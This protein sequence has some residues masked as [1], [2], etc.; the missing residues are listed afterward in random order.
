MYILNR[1][2]GRW[3]TDEVGLHLAGGVFRE[4]LAGAHLLR[5]RLHNEERSLEAERT[6]KVTLFEFVFMLAHVAHRSIQQ[7]LTPGLGKETWESLTAGLALELHGLLEP[8]SMEEI[9]VAQKRMFV[10]LLDFERRF[11]SHPLTPVSEKSFTTTLPYVFARDLAKSLT[12]KDTALLAA[13]ITAAALAAIRALDLTRS[14]GRA[15]IAR[16]S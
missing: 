13:E 5:R 1:L 4:A 2:L 16:E 8:L 12:P 9:E 3:S 10:G 14:L 15:Q 7:L 11:A 6:F